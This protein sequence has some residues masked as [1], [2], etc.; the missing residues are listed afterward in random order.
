MHFQTAAISIL[1]KMTN[2]FNAVGTKPQIRQTAMRNYRPAAS[3]T[4]EL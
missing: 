1:V 2:L 3:T 4:F